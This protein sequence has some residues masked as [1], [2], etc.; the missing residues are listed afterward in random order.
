MRKLLVLFG[1]AGVAALAAKKLQH[2]EP[3]WHTPD[4]DAQTD[5]L[6]ADQDDDQWVADDVGGSSPDEALSDAVVEPHEATSPDAPVQETVID[7][8]PSP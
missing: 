3:V 2:Q 6:A 5:D 4:T 1:L 7:D 8:E